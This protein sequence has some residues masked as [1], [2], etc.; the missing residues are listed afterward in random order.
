MGRSVKQPIG[1]GPPLPFWSRP[2]TLRVVVVAKWLKR[3]LDHR[4]RHRFDRRGLHLVNEIRQLRLERSHY[5][6]DGLRRRRRGTSPPRIKSNRG[7]VI[8]RSGT[9]GARS[10]AET[11]RNFE[12][13]RP[14]ARR[15]S[16]ATPKRSA[17]H[18]RCLP[19]WRI[20]PSLLRHGH[21][22]STPCRTRTH[23]RFS[24]LRSTRLRKPTPAHSLHL[25]YSCDCCH[26]HS[27]WEFVRS[28]QGPEPKRRH[29][30]PPRPTPS[31]LRTIRRLQ[32]QAF[33]ELVRTHARSIPAH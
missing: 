17:N 24:S 5:R 18:A 29:T 31:N 23:H 9:R 3:N 19:H 1:A 2:N 27:F 30:A 8:H 6:H 26:H 14:E 4:E 7:I 28:K 33:L 12:P 32:S 11:R 25:T 21:E 15:G 13:A 20:R 22:P 16:R 10:A